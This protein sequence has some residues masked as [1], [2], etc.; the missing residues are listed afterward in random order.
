MIKDVRTGERKYA[1]YR[2]ESVVLKD[3]AVL[4]AIA[5]NKEFTLVLDVEG[6]EGVTALRIVPAEGM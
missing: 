6:S 2:T 5:N 1:K 4:E 3:E